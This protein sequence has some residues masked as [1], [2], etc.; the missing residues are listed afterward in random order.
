MDHI[1]TSLVTG[2]AGMLGTALVPAL[3]E[4]GGRVHATD[5]VIG[6][7][8]DSLDVRDF[9][10]VRALCHKFLPSRVFHLAAETDVEKCE[11]D[12]DHAYRTNALG[13]QNVCLAARE[14]KATLIYISTA[15]VF[16]GQKKTP[17]TEFDQPNPLNVYGRAKLEGEHFVEK[18]MD[19]YFI[20][21]AGWMMGGGPKDKKFVGQIVKQVR[22]GEKLLHVVNDK[23]GTPTYTVDFSRMICQLSKCEIYGTYHTVCTGLTSRLEVA[24]EILDCLGR[25]DI[26]IVPVTSDFF[27]DTYSA[28]RAP[29]ERMRNYLLELRG[30]NTMRTW[31]T[32]LREYLSREFGETGV[33]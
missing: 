1:E 19:K 7:G 33:K 24:R 14:I 10:E 8:V 4:D 23:V 31:Q 9:K 5:V 13:T 26:E 17:Y 2:A 30:W 32:A 3:R 18:L 27:K 11:A 29:S 25:K 22:S 20:V 6:P 28:P 21:R 16:D 15:G 12:P